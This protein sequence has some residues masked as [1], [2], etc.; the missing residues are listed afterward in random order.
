LGE[1]PKPTQER[2]I[3]TIF[4]RNDGQ[5]D[6]MISAACTAN[7]LELPQEC[8]SALTSHESF[9]PQLGMTDLDFFGPQLDMAY[10]NFSGPQLDMAELDSVDAQ[11]SMDPFE[12][13]PLSSNHLWQASD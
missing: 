12:S 2:E 5:F 1:V 8:P 4:N 7:S 10:L 3:E 9:E 6:Q 11:P 13:E